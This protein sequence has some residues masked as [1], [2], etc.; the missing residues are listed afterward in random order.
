MMSA[1]LSRRFGQQLGVDY[2]E[3]KGEDNLNTA[4]FIVGKY[5]TPDLFMSYEHSIGTLGGGS[6]TPG[7]D[8]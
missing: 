7:C 4:T 8:G 5:I 1:E 6:S 2:I 3:I